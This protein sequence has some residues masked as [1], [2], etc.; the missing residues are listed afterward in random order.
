[1]QDYT[2]LLARKA[3]TAP[4]VGFR[5]DDIAGHLFG[6]QADLVRWA[7]MKGRAA[8]FADTGLGKTIMQ[9]EW[10]RHVS[11]R[12]HVLIVAPLAVAAQ[13]VAEAARFGVD[14]SYAK[15]DAERTD[16]LITI[17]NYER[18]ANFDAGAFAGVVLDESS[19]L[20]NYAGKVRSQI[21]DAFRETPY[22]LACTA[23]PAPNDI[24]EIANHAEFLGVMT[25]RGMLAAFFVH[26]D[27]GWR[28][29]RPAR[30]PFYRWMA[31][32]GMHIRKPSDLGYDDGG[33]DLPP[34]SIAPQY[35]ATD[36][37]PDG[38][39]FPVSVGGIATRGAARKATVADRVAAAAAIVS[40]EPD[41]QWLIWCGLNDEAD[42]IAAMIPGAVN[43]QGSDSPE[44]KAAN[45]LAFA[46]GSIR[47]MVT[48]PSIAGFGMNFQGCAR[49]VF[50][51]MGD[52]YEQYYQSIRRSW[53]FGQDRPVNVHIVLSDVEDTIFQ[54][55]IR[56]EKEAKAMGD[57]LIAEVAQYEMQEVAGLAEETDE[58]VTGEATGNGWRLMLGDS[59]ERLSEIADKSIGM[60]VF[61]PPFASLYQYSNSP[62]DLGNCSDAGQF[63]QQFG[64][65]SAQLVRV[66]MPGR[67]VCVHV[68]QI[69]TLKE[70]DGIIGLS[71]FRGDTIRHFVG[72]GF[73]YHGEV[74]I[75]KD[76]QA[77]SI[78]TRA[79]GLGFVQIDRDSSWMRPALAD[80]ILL[81]RTPGENA[82]PIDRH[83][84]NNEWIEYARPIWYGIRETETLNTAEAK[85]QDDEKHICPLQLGTIE[86]CLKLWSNPGDL[87]LSPFAGIGS[88]GHEAVRMG[89]Q[90]VGCEL[91]ESYFR[92][93]CRNLKAAEGKA[94]GDLFAWAN[95]SEAEVPA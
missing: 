26:D 44:S 41:E 6:F 58:Y 93:A 74:C 95:R 77:Q 30:Q 62:R 85:G 78:R 53:R 89:R 82:I 25:R 35:V 16:S 1:M 11:D 75:D 47:V 28:L 18:L 15:S 91:K 46:A 57:S 39:L 42:S 73:V 34:L 69:P 94:V 27:T 9:I 71:D 36:Y 14:I 38:Y 7:L 64:F 13:T 4:A 24:A 90:F 52:S 23:T 88:E 31:S 81:F 29:K 79:K 32:W 40:N 20:K 67:I 83:M 17:T 19:I 48:K 68:S 76:P 54:N 3:M 43:V 80:Y 70:R 55:V 60:S 50:V 51:G 87:V 72:A 5:T 2:E 65:I 56:K 61:S 92:A 66:M 22:R 10:A 45:L 12:G 37:I 33:F 84:T 21:I 63:W 59:S 8:I 86:R 49:Q